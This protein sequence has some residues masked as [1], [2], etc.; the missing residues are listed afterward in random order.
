VR[1]IHTGPPTAKADDAGSQKLAAA[2]APT[3]IHTARADQS[4]AST[5]MRRS[6]HRFYN[7]ASINPPRL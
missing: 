7:D 1:T 2:A 4:A 3:T 5:T 6:T